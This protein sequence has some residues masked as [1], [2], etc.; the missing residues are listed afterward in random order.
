MGCEIKFKEIIIIHLVLYNPHTQSQQGIHYKISK[1]ET[2]CCASYN[3][4]HK[5]ELHWTVLVSSNIGLKLRL[6]KL[7]TTSKT[8]KEYQIIKIF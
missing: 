5:I 4:I 6:K 8:S 1:I 7:Q 2:F 3:K